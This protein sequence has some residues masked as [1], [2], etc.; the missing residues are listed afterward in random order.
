VQ[1]PR[2]K[3]VEALDL[4][5]DQHRFVEIR[6]GAGVG[7]SAVLKH[8]AERIAAQANVLVLDPVSTPE[9][10]WPALAQ[11]L[12]LQ[13]TTQEFLGDLATSGGGVVF[14]DSLE[15]FTSPA[16]RRTV[17]DLLR[18]IATIEGLSVVAT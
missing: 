16:R 12:D 1:L 18:E 9:G 7:K 10:G 3:A 15:M 6:G 8:V 5:L 14:I 17:N 11:T 13:A 2:L 4:A